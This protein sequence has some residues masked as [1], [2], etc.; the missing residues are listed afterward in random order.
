MLKE[1]TNSD[2]TTFSVKYLYGFLGIIN[3]QLL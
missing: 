3:L 2:F 1:Q